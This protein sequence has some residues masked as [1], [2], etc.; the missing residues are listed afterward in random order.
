MGPPG[1]WQGAGHSEVVIVAKRLMVLALVGL[2]AGGCA[3]MRFQKPPATGLARCGIV[4]IPF[5]HGLDASEDVVYQEAN[6]IEKREDEG[7]K[8]ALPEP[9]FFFIT[10]GSL[11]TGS[12][13]YTKMP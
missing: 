8:A 1:S 5:W 6:C 2:V 11:Y 7:Y 13:T 9:Y 10:S 4:Q 12:P 3:Y